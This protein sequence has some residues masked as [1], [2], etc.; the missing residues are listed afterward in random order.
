MSLSLFRSIFSME[1]RTLLSYRMSFWLKLFGKAFFSMVFTYFLWKSLWASRS[2]PLTGGFSL[3]E[4][5]T[6]SFLVPLISEMIQGLGMRIVS[7]DIYDGSLT[8]FLIF[9]VSF[10]QFKIVSQ[11]ANT[12]MIL[13]QSIVSV[14]LLWIFFRYN[15]LAGLDFKLIL[16]FLF[17][18]FSGSILFLLIQ[19]IVEYFAFWA[20]NVWSLSVMNFFC[21]QLLG[22]F[23]IPLSFFPKWAQTVLFYLPYSHLISDPTLLIMG[24]M[25]LNQWFINS[26]ITWSWILILA[27]LAKFVWNQGTKNYTGVGI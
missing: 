21:L 3:S 27:L 9:P 2:L 15:I 14:L 25:D 22:G 19:L 24:K 11:L 1:M 6:Y 13:C 5:V 16:P 26:L 23:M 8:K 12:V 20:D 17:T 18:I 4:I 7:Q 10:L